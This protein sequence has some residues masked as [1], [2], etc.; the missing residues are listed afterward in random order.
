M[1]RAVMGAPSVQKDNR[2]SKEVWRKPIWG[3]SL[4]YELPT[5]RFESGLG[6]GE[7]MVQTLESRHYQI[8][9]DRILDKF[10]QIGGQ[11]WATLLFLGR[12]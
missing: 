1:L 5:L 4:P 3:P 9:E 8:M 12:T 11:Q 7:I 6:T 2:G 10:P